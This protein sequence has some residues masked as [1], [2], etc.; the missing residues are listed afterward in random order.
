MR[1]F[2]CKQ[3]YTCA[4]I[5][6]DHFSD[7]TY[8]HL[9]RSI[10][11]EDTLVAFRAFENFCDRHGVEVRHYH[12]DNCRFADQGFLDSL[13]DRSRQSVFAALAH[14]GRTKKRKNAFEIRKTK[15][16]RYYYILYHYGLKHPTLTC[17]RMRYITLSTFV[18]TFLA[19]KLVFHRCNNLQGLMLPQDL[20]PFIHLVALSTN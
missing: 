3:R 1:G 9:Q 12:A 14:T 13:R 10:S 20:Q 6:V 18:T 17:G 7:L 11:L 4:T 15:A 19:I 5:F 2:I 8:T 16:E